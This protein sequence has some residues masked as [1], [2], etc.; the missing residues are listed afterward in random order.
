M[1][2]SEFLQ[3]FYLPNQ[4]GGLDGYKSKNKTAWFFFE[5]GLDA[6]YD[7]NI[8][9]PSYSSLE[10]WVSGSRKPE[11]SVWGEASKH[12]NEVKLAKK[13]LNV[14]NA[15]NLKE[16]M[17][18]FGITFEIAEVPD[19]KMFSAAVAAQ[20]AAIVNGYGTADNI[21]PTEYKKAP[22]PVGFKNYLC[23]AE[24]RYKWVKLPGED[25]CLLSDVFVCNN[26]GTS[27]AVF[28]NRITGNCIENATLEKLRT[29]DRRGEVLKIILIGGCGYGKTLMLQ[30]LFIE[31]AENSDE[32]GRLPI[33]AELRNF[34]SRYDGFLPFIVDTVREYDDSFTENSAKE[35]LERGQAQI[36]FDGL[37]ELDPGEVK[38]FQKKIAEFTN[39]YQNVQVIITSRQCSAIEGVRGFARLY[40]HPLNEGQVNLLLDK[41]LLR[42]HN[43]E[44]K[45]AV[46]SF[47]D[48]ETGYLRRGGFIA[49]NPML[50]TVIVSNCEKLKDLT[51]DKSSLYEMLYDVLI[52]GHD[53]EKEAFDRFF[54]S[55]GSSEEFTQVFRAFCALT[56]MDGIFEF[57]HRTFEKYFKYVKKQEELE[58]PNIF[59]LSGFE[60]DVC[61]TAC[62]MYE[63]E[64]GIYYIDPG[65]QDYFFAEYYYFEDTEKTK[66]MGEVLQH[67]KVKSFRN[68]D[69]LRMLYHMS[70]DKV[71]VCMILP[72]LREIFRDTDEKETF[73]RFLSYGYKECIYTE[74]DETAVKRYKP[75][76]GADK[77][78]YIMDTNSPRNIL[79]ALIL[80]IL[81]LNN[82]F[83][84]SAS[85]DPI[86]REN[87]AT[88]FL[89]GFT[90]AYV[91]QEDMKQHTAIRTI[92]N[93]IQYL[94]SSSN[95]EYNLA[96]PEMIRDEEGK[97]VCFGY[98][99]EV[100]PLLLL[101]DAARAERFIAMA[102]TAGMIEIYKK[103]KIYYEKI[104]EAQKENDFR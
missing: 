15:K 68:L 8:I 23:G 59:L 6:D 69:G 96:M 34:S 58:N 85:V 77:F 88:H 90:Q 79:M 1:E 28:P 51:E 86:K 39:R 89:N 83:T 73:M 14:L 57:D 44:A 46:M 101:S 70:P 103:V 55:V 7:E 45:E 36:L 64:S 98:K 16:I 41:L 21:V 24:N 102:K 92:D 26:I 22:E 20:F 62:M 42:K 40:L 104:V 95:P 29:Y 100:D 61:A 13:L 5:N 72:F 82:S 66:A 67:R 78:D 17:Q 76:V 9:I 30:H 11:S 47:F 32:T 54:H 48:P 12:L 81:D 99:Y 3:K 4:G 10:K 94:D 19:R 93:D 53:E 65:F 27:A 37:D 75:K 18:S 91:S 49:T 35:V 63:Q 87:G 80:D 74:I 50:L 38:Y 31:A 52:R 56:Y 60:H 97:T 84:L 43:A 2:Y 25:E 33:M 71:E